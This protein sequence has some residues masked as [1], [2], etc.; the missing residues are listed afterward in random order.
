MQQYRKIIHI[1][2]DAFYASVEQRDFPGLRGKPVAVGGGGR[3][4]VIAAASY[5]ARKFGVHSAMPG[6]LARQK[7]PQLIFA[8]TRFEVYQEVSAQVREIFHAETDLV[9]PLSLDEAYLDVTD[10]NSGQPSAT[11][12]AKKLQKQIY[13]ATGLTASAGVSYC[14]FLAK[15]AS[16]WQK[17]RGLTVIE[18]HQGLKFLEELPIERFHGIGTRTTEKMHKL[19]IRTGKDLLAYT[20]PELVGKFGKAGA[21]Y[22]SLVRGQDNRPVNPSRERKSIGKERTFAED[23]SS[24]E[25]M[26]EELAELCKLVFE[27]MEQKQLFGR[28][29]TLK[30]KDPQFQ[31]S[32][33]S[34]SLQQPVRSLTELQKAVTALLNA[35]LSKMPEVRLLGVAV[36]GFYGAEQG[37]LEILFDE[38]ISG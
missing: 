14:K 28:T 18:P 24:P 22:Y 38:C 13:Q 6:Y 15:T 1:D 5:E 4:G 16:G 11:L 10:N 34:H 23:L 32:S 19:N 12:L 20:L 8:R 37:Q 3:R 31:N 35:T 21:W 27:R 2:M 26:A 7:C 9:E 36:S 33:R 25:Q 30:W 17:P 29:V